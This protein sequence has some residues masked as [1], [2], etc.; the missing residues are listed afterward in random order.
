MFPPVFWKNI[1]QNTNIA[2]KNRP[3]ICKDFEAAVK[4]LHVIEKLGC[5]TTEKK[6]ILSEFNFSQRVSVNFVKKKSSQNTD[7]RLLNA[8]KR[9]LNIDADMRR[10]MFALIDDY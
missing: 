7:S 3:D 8:N 1:D 4:M 5:T 2:F 6:L 10:N 9:K